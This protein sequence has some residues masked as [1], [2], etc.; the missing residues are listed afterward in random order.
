VPIIALVIWSATAFFG[1]Y[2][3]C[4][5]LAAGGIR[6]Q[7]IKVTKF[8][9]VLVCA[10]PLCALTGLGFWVRYVADNQ[11][12]DAWAAFGVL[13]GSALLGFALL[14]RWLTGQGGRHARGGEQRFPTYSV[15]LHG[16][17]GIVTFVLV[18][19]TATIASQ[20]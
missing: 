20:R 1:L 19:I 7:P 14:T 18:L 15:I 10:H 5:W 2:L 9:L 3:L 16:V 13:C 17:G 6:R 8:P 12:A 11:L 4:A